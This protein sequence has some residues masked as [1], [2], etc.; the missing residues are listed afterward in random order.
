MSGPDRVTKLC[1]GCGIILDRD[2]AVCPRCRTVQPDAPP[3]T[4]PDALRAPGGRASGSR[5]FATAPAASGGL[6]A[7]PPGARGLYAPEAGAVAGYD[8]DA[9]SE[10]R[11]LIAFL[12]CFFCPLL[13]VH[14]FYLK[15][16][17]T[18]VLMLLTAGGMGIWW[19][20]DLVTLLFGAFR[21]GDGRKVSEWV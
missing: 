5:R 12:L 9:P 15:K 16:P 4:T 11:L 3:G 14:R 13:G 21:D 8:P 20:I 7:A 6:R 1:S 10:R 19:L 18:G 17:G 2:A